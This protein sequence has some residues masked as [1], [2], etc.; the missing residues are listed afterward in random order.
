M[1]KNTSP[2]R[3]P[4]FL[5]YGSP[6]PVTHTRRATSPRI[7]HKRLPNYDSIQSELLRNGCG[8][9]KSPTP[10]SIPPASFSKAV[11]SRRNFR[12]PGS[13]G[14]KI[15]LRWGRPFNRYFSPFCVRDRLADYDGIALRR[16]WRGKTP[17]DWFAVSL[18]RDWLKYL[19]N[20]IR[21]AIPCRRRDF[22]CDT[23][24]STKPIATIEMWKFIRYRLEVSR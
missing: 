10:R 21:L 9:L 13:T 23:R 16:Y 8:E 15:P 24:E 22:I 1:I 5:S 17:P 19:D 7:M 20:R 18:Q 12:S 2:T 11:N 3:I 4:G 6:T 14:E